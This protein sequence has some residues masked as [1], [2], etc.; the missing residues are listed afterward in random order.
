V[1]AKSLQSGAFLDYLNET[2]R[3]CGLP[4]RRLQ[5]EVTE[6]VFIEDSS[7]ALEALAKIRG[8]GIS[9]AL[10][11]FGSGYSSLRYLADFELDRVKLDKSFLD[12]LEF[13]KKKQNIIGGIIALANS[14]GVRVIAEGVENETQLAFLIAQGCHG[15][16]GFLMAK[17]VDDRLFTNHLTARHGNR[18][19]KP[20]LK[21]AASA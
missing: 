10:D 1:S 8:M 19:K 16:Q 7:N 12:D 9:I 5:L 20:S 21:L 3:Q 18:G 11:D 15:G 6:G 17:P 13:S 14:L 4:A 2:L